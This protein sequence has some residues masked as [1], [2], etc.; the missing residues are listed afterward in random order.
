MK[1]TYILIPILLII[2]IL[3]IL[4]LIT[5]TSYEIFAK[6][7]RRNIKD[8]KYDF[9]VDVRTK[10]EWDEDHLHNTISIP[11]GNLVSELPERIPNRNARILFICKKGIRASGVVTIAHKLGYNNVESMNGNYKEIM[12]L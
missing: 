4:H 10:Q 5:T 2:F 6:E 3:I 7:A 11:I 12:L 9:I 1:L 8:G